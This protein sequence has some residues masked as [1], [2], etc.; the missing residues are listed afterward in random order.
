MTDYQS[1]QLALRKMQIKYG[2]ME[3]TLP[4]TYKEKNEAYSKAFN[5]GKGFIVGYNTFIYRTHG[6]PGK[7]TIGNNVVIGNHC[8]IDYS[9]ELIIEDNVVISDG[10]KIYT[11]DHDPYLY[12][13]KAENNVIP[14]RVVIKNNSWIGSGAII[15]ANV[16]I[17]SFSVVG[18]G[19]VVTHS[20][21]DEMIY[22]GNPAKS[23]G[24]NCPKEKK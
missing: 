3:Y 7:I 17:G 12:T 8:E 1:E 20:V 4:D 9:G 19:S 6:L 18:A 16:E 24:K 13:H 22:A 2:S 11:H 5:T 15:T 10:V 14:G 21:P 23:I